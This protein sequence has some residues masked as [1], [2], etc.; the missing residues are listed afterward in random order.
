MIR[1][2]IKGLWG[3]DAVGTLIH[4][5]EH[6]HR[7]MTDSSLRNHFGAGECPL[8]GRGP[9]IKKPGRKNAMTINWDGAGG[10]AEPGLVLGG[11]SSG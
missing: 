3:T 8:P 9:L 4:S 2:L 6:R 7:C 5:R 10:R 1:R 11:G